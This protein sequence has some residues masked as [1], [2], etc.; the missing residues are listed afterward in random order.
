MIFLLFRDM[1]F[2]MPLYEEIVIASFTGLTSM[3]TYVVGKIARSPILQLVA[4]I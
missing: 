3:G 1:G 2:I 4:R